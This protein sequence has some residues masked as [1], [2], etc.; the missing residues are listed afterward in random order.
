V[1]TA[2]RRI[3]FLGELAQNAKKMFAKCANA[4]K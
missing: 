3:P 1:I 2:V 4:V